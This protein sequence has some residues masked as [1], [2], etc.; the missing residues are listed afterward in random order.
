MSKYINIEL[1][2]TTDEGDFPEHEG[3]YDN[4][5]DAK[6]ALERLEKLYNDGAL[7]ED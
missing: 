6:E 2:Y 7:H 1:S 5:E 3:Y 4:F